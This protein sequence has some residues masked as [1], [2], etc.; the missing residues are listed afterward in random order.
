[1]DIFVVFFV[2]GCY[3]I[4]CQKKDDFGNLYIDGLDIGE[5]DCYIQG[6]NVLRLSVGCYFLFLFNEIEV[7]F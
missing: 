7:L 4:L 2:C 6:K 5:R 1:M 3:D